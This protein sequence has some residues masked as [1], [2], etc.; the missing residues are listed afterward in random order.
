MQVHEEGKTLKDCAQQHCSNVNSGTGIA[1]PLFKARIEE[2]HEVN[3][4]AEVFHDNG[5]K[6]A[7]A[8]AVAKLGA[9]WSLDKLVPLMI[10]VA[11]ALTCAIFRCNVI[12]GG[13]NIVAGG[14][15]FGRATYRIQQLFS[16]MLGHSIKYATTEEKEMLD[17][18]A[19]S[20][21][22]ASDP[23]LMVRPRHRII[24]CIT[25]RDGGV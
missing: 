7:T 13:L 16:T 24:A 23:G 10:N 9:Q 17:Q 8:R 25:S 3:V 6:D 14:H 5:I 1:G 15:C 4:T 11:E 2:G 22:F 18:L 12:F 19:A 20:K 21:A